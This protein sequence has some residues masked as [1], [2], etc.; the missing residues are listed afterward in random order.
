MKKESV[1]SRRWCIS[2]LSLRVQCFT[3]CLIALA[4][5]VFWSPPSWAFVAQSSSCMPYQLRFDP[6][7]YP[8]VFRP[9]TPNNVIRFRV[10]N[11]QNPYGS[12]G[13]IPWMQIWVD[14]IPLTT[15]I[16]NATHSGY[17][18]WNTTGALNPSAHTT[19]AMAEVVTSFPGWSVTTYLDSR[20]PLPPNPIPL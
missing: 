3:F 18:Y 17:A 15:Y 19:M 10:V 11:Y 8:L 16:D 5:V 13:T 1:P 6:G 20:D 14:D 2:P 4:T 7:A 12:V 9:D